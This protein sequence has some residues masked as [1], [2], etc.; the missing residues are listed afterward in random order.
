MPWVLIHIFAFSLSDTFDTIGTFIGTGRKSGIFDEADERALETGSG[1]ASRMDKALFADSTATSIGALLG[2]S[3]TT[4][5]IESAAGIEAGG[6]T[7]LT[8]VVVAILFLLTIP[9]ASVVGLVPAAATAP[10]LIFVGVLMAEALLGIAWND[11]TEAIPAF[12]TIT[13]MTF[14]Y[15]ISYGIAAGF[16]TYCIINLIKGRGK[17]VHPILYGAAILFLLNFVLIA[18]NKL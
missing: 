8:S 16:I 2:T 14:G 7:G 9:F 1:F 11:L 10:A 18:F 12:L 13:V 3:N 4:T 15:N 6:R 5:Y 17:R